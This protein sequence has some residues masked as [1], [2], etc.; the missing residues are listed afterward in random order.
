[1][2]Y[3]EIAPPNDLTSVI[4]CFWFLEHD[5]RAA[6][7]THEHL[8]AT[9]HA[10]LIFSFGARYYLKTGTG[11]RELPANF[12]IGPCQKNLVLYSSGFTGLV[13]IRF[14]PWGVFP[15]SIKPLTHLINRIEPAEEVLGDGINDLVRSMSGQERATK[16]E[17]MQNY[18]Q[19]KSEAMTRKKIA[20]APMGEKIISENGMIKISELANRFQIDFRQ[21]ERLFRRETGLTPKMFARIVR[22]NRA[23]RMMEHDTNIDL[24]RVAY[25]MGY[26]DQAHFSNDFRKLFNYSPADFKNRVKTFRDE[27]TGQIDVE[28]LQDDQS[29][30]S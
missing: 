30:A 20:S 9:V 15:F 26:S 12:V 4:E 27:A 21:L 17:L 10:E 23:R 5:Y 28:F 25:D 13:A 24:S 3:K 16:V 29:G 22:F 8:W 19:E 14:K 1:M 7:H 18:F 2:V 6:F 11:K